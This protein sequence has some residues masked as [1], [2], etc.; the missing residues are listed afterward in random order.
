MDGSISL[1]TS[2]GAPAETF[3]AL[4]DVA[5]TDLRDL[6]P[7]IGETC[8]ALSLTLREG[9]VAAASRLYGFLL[10]QVP[11]RR[12][13][14]ADVLRPLIS[15]DLRSLSTADERRSYVSTC[16]Q[17]LQS[18]RPTTRRHDPGVTLF[19]WNDGSDVLALL[20]VALLL[21]EV[22]VA[23]TVTVGGDDAGLLHA[24]GRRRDGVVC[25][26]APDELTVTRATSVIA[27]LRKMANVVLLGDRVRRT[28]ALV[29]NLGATAGTARV[30]EAADLVLHLRGPLTA[31]EAAVLRLA[32]DGYTNVRIAHELGISLSAVKARFESGYTRLQA[33][34]R[35]HAVAIALRQRWIR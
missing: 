14:L 8:N 6:S 17:L 1:R 16:R 28:P 7:A 3:I 21:D 2:P 15:A 18:L 12:L 20:M 29:R 19:A 32:A 13:A 35:T 33:S 9:D 23:A 26:P 4:P 24:V 27:S 11:D 10:D 25:T 22:G 34:D 30:D 5:D 31:A